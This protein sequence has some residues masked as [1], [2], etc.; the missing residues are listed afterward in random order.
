MNLSSKRIRTLLIPV[1]VAVSILILY[2]LFRSVNLAETYKVLSQVNLPLLGVSVVFFILS[3]LAI[4]FAL[5]G[6]LKA[7]DAAPP[8]RTTQLA[9]FGGQLLSDITPAKSGYFAT[10]IL[11]NQLKAVPIE[12]GL[13]SVMSVGAVNFFIKAVFSTIALIYFLTR[14]SIDA[15]MMNAML[16]GITLL[17]AGGIGLTVLVWTNF[18]SGVLQKLSKLPLIGVVIRKLES[19]RATFAKDKTAMRK[20][21]K[22]S[23]ASV[24]ASVVLSGISLY[25]LAQAI[26][27]TQPTFQ[28]LLF[29]GPL[30]A[31]FMYVPVTFAGLGLQ[32]AAYVFLLTNIGA[33]LEVAL[34]FALLIRILS[35][36]TDLIGLPPLIKTSTGLF[37]RLG[38]N[39]P[40]EKEKQNP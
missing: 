21:A 11:L 5:Y 14:I 1:Q 36:T 29:M 40:L 9:N 18:L 10:P 7:A 25:I 19:I 16:I 37:N 22:T 12:K 39:N 20:S 2:L 17:L 38:K 24:I 23:I 34:P 32:E 27:L 28:D 30:T 33:P 3:S 26:G 4:G 31:V 13:M 6:A 35:V 15:Y 8:M